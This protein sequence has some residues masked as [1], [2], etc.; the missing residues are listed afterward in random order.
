MGKVININKIENDIAKLK[1]TG[2]M[3]KINNGKYAIKHLEVE[4]LAYKYNIETNIDLKFCD[5]TKGCAVVKGVAVFN[6]KKFFC[7]S[8]LTHNETCAKNNTWHQIPS[9]FIY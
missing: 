3:W 7:D 1:S 2:G 9:L 4:K 8:N 5:L 6:G